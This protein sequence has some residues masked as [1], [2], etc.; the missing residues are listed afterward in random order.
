M[1]REEEI[2]KERERKIQEL[3]DI[4]INPYAYK[5]EKKNLVADCLKARLGTGAKTA[6]RIMTKREIGKIIFS[7]LMDF[8]GRVQLV[9]QAGKTGNG[10]QSQQI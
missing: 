4:G 10:T 2:I 9:F 7:D 3:K 8:S 1:G 5:F 6:G